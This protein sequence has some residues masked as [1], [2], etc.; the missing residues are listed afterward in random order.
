M[1]YIPIA[2]KFLATP[3]YKKESFKKRVIESGSQKRDDL[4]LFKIEKL[5]KPIDFKHC[6]QKGK[7]KQ[8]KE[9]VKTSFYLYNKLKE[10][11][12]VAI[13]IGA[14]TELIL[15]GK[16]QYILQLFDIVAKVHNYN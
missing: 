6:F 13:V 7:N 10:G 15:N 8:Q 14:G 12:I 5:G 3:L 11:D 4:K 1:N 16:V 9:L 2:G